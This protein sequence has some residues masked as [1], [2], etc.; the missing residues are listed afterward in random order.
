M[1]EL[2]DDFQLNQV[3][4]FSMGDKERVNDNSNYHHETLV[5]LSVFS[6]KLACVL[7]ISF[8]NHSLVHILVEHKKMSA[9]NFYQQHCTIQKLCQTHIVKWLSIRTSLISF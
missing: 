4:H 5:L 3:S 6:S 2:T 7:D 9:H 1:P 8:L